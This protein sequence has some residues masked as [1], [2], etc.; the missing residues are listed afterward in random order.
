LR[1]QCQPFQHV[2]DLVDADDSFQLPGFF[3]ELDANLPKIAMTAL[4]ETLA[5]RANRAGRLGITGLLSK[6]TLGQSPRQLQFAEMRLAL[7]KL[8]MPKTLRPEGRHRAGKQGLLPGTEAHAAIQ[9]PTAARTC[10]T[11]SSCG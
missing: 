8:R 10:R 9:R 6:Q 5:G 4:L 3:I 7:Q 1:G 2:A 11:T